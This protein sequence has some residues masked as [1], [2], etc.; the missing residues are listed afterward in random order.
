VSKAGLLRPFWIFEALV[1]VPE[2]VVDFPVIVHATFWDTKEESQPE[3]L[4][5]EIRNLEIHDGEDVVVRP[6][7]KAL[8]P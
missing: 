2:V 1:P 3:T 7:P 6:G 4:R 8:E 5:T